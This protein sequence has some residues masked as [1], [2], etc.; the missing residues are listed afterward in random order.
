MVKGWWTGNYNATAW[1]FTLV[2]LAL[3]LIGLIYYATRRRCYGN[4][5]RQDV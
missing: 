2:A 4:I 1:I 3:C 5:G